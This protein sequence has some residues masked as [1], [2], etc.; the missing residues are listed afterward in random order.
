MWASDDCRGRCANGTGEGTGRSGEVEQ[1]GVLRGTGS[2]LGGTDRVL[3][4]TDQGACVIGVVDGAMRSVING[5]CRG[6]KLESMV[7]S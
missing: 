4:G 6:A 5:R 7:G 3:G 1:V 2:L